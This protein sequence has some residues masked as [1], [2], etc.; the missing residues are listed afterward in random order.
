MTPC[1]NPDGPPSTFS[2][3]DEMARIENE[4]EQAIRLRYLRGLVRTAKAKQESFTHVSVDALEGLLS[5]L[6]EAEENT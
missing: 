2:H 1:N 4:A 5:K 3:G 6:S